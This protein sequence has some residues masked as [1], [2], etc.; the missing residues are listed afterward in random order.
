MIK[1]KM[2]QAIG[3]EA[4]PKAGSAGLVS[5]EFRKLLTPLP[6]MDRSSFLRT[7]GVPATASEEGCLPTRRCTHTRARQILVFLIYH[8]QPFSSKQRPFVLPLPD[9]RDHWEAERLGGRHTGKGGV[10]GEVCLW[11]RPRSGQE[12]RPWAKGRAPGE[13]KGEVN[14]PARH[15]YPWSLPEPQLDLDQGNVLGGRSP[16]ALSPQ[17]Q[18]AGRV[19]WGWSRGCPQWSGEPGRP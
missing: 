3:L 4:R 1:T 13:G 5:L 12:T 16:N 17:G 19:A 10:Q 18:K 9:H 6:S 7:P 8:R 15:H 2:T 11:Q 14:Q